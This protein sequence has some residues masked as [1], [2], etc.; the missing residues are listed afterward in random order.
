MATSQDLK[1][2]GTSFFLIVGI[3]IVLFA[4]VAYFVGKSRGE[5]EYRHISGFAW[6]KDEW[7]KRTKGLRT[8]YNPDSDLNTEALTLVPGDERWLDF[9]FWSF[10][11][12]LAEHQVEAYGG[13]EWEGPQGG[14]IFHWAPGSRWETHTL[15]SFGFTIGHTIGEHKWM[16]T[17][18]PDFFE[19]YGGVYGINV[20]DRLAE[21]DHASPAPWVDFLEYSGGANSPYY[22]YLFHQEAVIDPVRDRI[23]LVGGQGVGFEYTFERYYHEVREV[24][25]DARA[26]QFFQLYDLYG[27][28]FASRGGWAK[29]KLSAALHGIYFTDDISKWSTKPGVAKA[30]KYNPNPP[31]PTIPEGFPERDAAL[32]GQQLYNK[33]CTPCHGILGDGKGFLAAGFD[34]KPRDFRQGTYKFRSTKTGQLPTI[35]DV[36]K[37]IQVGVPNTTM[38]AWGQF[39]SKDQ[40][41]DLA[42]YLIVFSE[43]FTGAWKD[44]QKP[45][46]LTISAV[47][48]DLMSLAS[49]GKKF[50]QVMQCAKCH[51]DAGKG[52]GP[53]APD[54]KDEWENPINPTD[55]TYKWQ[56]KNGHMAE[57]VYRT[58]N[59]GLNGTPMPSYLDSFENDRDRWALVAYVLS[60][61]PEKRPILPLSQ[62]KQKISKVLD[63]NGIVRE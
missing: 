12:K 63:A 62:F 9:V 18:F 21:I 41:H 49:S 60:L 4:V 55:L 22:R 59:G 20:K 40:I 38:P 53:S 8:S 45:D 30:V 1:R 52:N 6:G 39:F 19:K 32:R 16:D 33:Q 42:I 34:V 7:A 27:P 14:V 13:T 5:K 44:G 58:F 24:L 10:N 25:T 17:Q 61:S 51:G 50:Y 23:Y 31:S 37:I 3:V 54:L 57:D 43:K 26:F 35:K 11:N 36:E 29:N 47:P 48:T 56:F 2:Q 15:A 28:G 46:A